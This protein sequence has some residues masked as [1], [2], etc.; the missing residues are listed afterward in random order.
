MKRDKIKTSKQK[1]ENENKSEK[2][3]KPPKWFYII[4]ILIPVVFIVLLE[5]FLR[6]VNY[7][8]VLEQFVAVSYYHPD[9]IYLNPD[10]PSKYFFNIKATPSVLPDGFD[11]VK[12][13]NAFRVFVLGESSAA[14]WPYVP[15]AS[16]SRQLK[17]KLE[18]YYPEN[19][20]EVIN[21]GISAINTYTIRDFVPGI[22]KQKPDLI[23][24]Y[25]GHNEYYGALGVGSTVNLGNSRFLV[26]TYLWAQDFR[27]VQLIQNSISWIY[28]LFSSIGNDGDDK[29][30]NET[31]MSRMI[32]ESLITLNSDSYNSGVSQFEGN[33]D[34]ILSWFKEANIPVIIG[35]LTCNLKD[36]KPFVSLKTENLPSAE[37]IYNNAKEQLSNRN[38]KKAK[39][40]F[41]YAKELDALRFRAPQQINN[42]IKSLSQKYNYTIVN[43]DSVFESLSPDGIVGYNLMV[44]HL[45]PNIDGY[46]FIADE[47]YKSMEEKHLV[48]KGKKNQ[49]N[50][51]TADSILIANFPFTRL[52]STIAKMQL[53][54][55]TGQ[56]PFVPKGLQTIK[57]KNIK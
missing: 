24:I 47:F 3:K 17:R 21:C 18:L 42:I 39:E 20:I 48:P 6:I 33:F 7:G 29:Q 15:N 27:T 23:L 44:D 26:N 41:L 37:D 28:G 55:L 38:I 53:I 8:V 50:S 14:G 57:L 2:A 36:Q 56:Y 31:L 45:H 25:T 54:I 19:T 49:I 43:I 11:K 35:N 51:V 12:K 40:L 34:D 1:S 22:I 32:G 9:K 10:L 4:L 30:K 52:D 13:D 16:F 46:R 5:A